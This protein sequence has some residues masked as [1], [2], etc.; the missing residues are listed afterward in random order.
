MLLEY[1][2][3]LDM[4]NRGDLL[5]CLGGSSANTTVLYSPRQRTTINQYTRRTME[6]QSSGAILWI[7]IQLLILLREWLILPTHCLKDTMHVSRQCF[8]R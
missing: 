6:L 8:P 7:D 2:V 4:K 1:C 3:F 5:C